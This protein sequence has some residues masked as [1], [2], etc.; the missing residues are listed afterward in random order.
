MILLE[1]HKHQ[2]LV[3]RVHGILTHQVVERE[4]QTQDQ[5]AVA[6]LVEQP[7]RQVV[8]EVQE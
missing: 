1:Q 3:E 4:T 2:V 5:V 6:V 8:Q 7:L